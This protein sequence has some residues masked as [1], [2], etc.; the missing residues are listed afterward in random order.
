MPPSGYDMKQVDSI[1]AFLKSCSQALRAESDARGESLPASLAREITGI[2]TFVDV[3]KPTALQE[4]VLRLTGEFYSL[5][6]KR[7]ERG[8]DYTNAVQDTLA[9]VSSNIRKIHI[10]E[11]A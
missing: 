6:L 3:E 8:L 2:A 5:T 11:L 7:M 4:S 1:T 10:R 9:E